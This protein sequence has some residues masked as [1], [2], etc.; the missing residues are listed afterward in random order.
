MSMKVSLSPTSRESEASGSKCSGRKRRREIVSKG[1]RIQPA[2]IQ[3]DLQAMTKGIGKWKGE[4]GGS[5]EKAT[6]GAWLQ[7]LQQVPLLGDGLQ[8]RLQLH[9]LYFL[10]SRKKGTASINIACP[11]SPPPLQFLWAP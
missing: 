1:D 7:H 10:K 9:A 8:L 4:G 6:A 11:W 3:T 2:P 5:R